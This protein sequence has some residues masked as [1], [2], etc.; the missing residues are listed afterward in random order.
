M[1]NE[2]FVGLY[3]ADGSLYDVR[4]TCVSVEHGNLRV[5][6]PFA[7]QFRRSVWTR[8][9]SFVAPMSDVQRSASARRFVHY[10]NGMARV[11]SRD[12]TPHE[13]RTARGLSVF[14]PSVALHARASEMRRSSC[15]THAVGRRRN[16]TVRICMM[17]SRSVRALYASHGYDVSC[18][19]SLKCRTARWR[20]CVG[21]NLP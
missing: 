6:R 12:A 15:H 7:T 4:S 2:R 10:S 8:M 1:I 18:H 3:S 14:G 16:I 20:Q 9:A 19:L 17:P 21:C 11:S 5:L 13:L